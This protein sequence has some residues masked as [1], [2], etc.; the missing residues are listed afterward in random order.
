MPSLTE[1]YAFVRRTSGIRKQD[2][3][4]THDLERDLGITGDDFFELAEDFSKEFNVN[5]T[6]YRWYFHHAEEVTFN[7][8]ALVFK[9][10]YRLVSHIPVTPALLLQAAKLGSWPVEYPEHKLPQRRYDLLFNYGLIAAIGVLL[11]VLS[12]HGE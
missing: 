3:Q 5:M 2:L 12:W 11:G 10:P 1:I 6:T 7:P 9:P 8:G 4:P